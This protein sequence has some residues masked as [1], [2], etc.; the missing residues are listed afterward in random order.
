LSELR[1]LSS[2]APNDRGKIEAARQNCVE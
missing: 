1:C 2:K